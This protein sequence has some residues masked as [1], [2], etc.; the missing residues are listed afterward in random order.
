MWRARRSAS[1]RGQLSKDGLRGKAGFEPVD[2]DVVG[3][4]ADLEQE[5]L[6]GAL[7]DE[8]RPVIQRL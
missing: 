3:P 7:E 2:G 1:T 8:I 4:G 5:G 6:L